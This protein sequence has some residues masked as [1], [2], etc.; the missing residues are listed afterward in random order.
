MTAMQVRLEKVGDAA[1][2]ATDGRGHTVVID[3]PAKLG[4]AD[5]G[6]RP[7]E[8]FLVSLAS[9][10]A[11]DVA[12]ILEQQRQD[13][14]GLT[15][16][17]DGTRADAVPAVYQTIDLSFVARGDVAP[18]K[19]ERAVRLSVDKYCSVRAMLRDDV[20]VTWQARVEAP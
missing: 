11:L 4:G 15:V 16:A 12:M 1:Y 9:C 5:R 13:L 7:M 3:G 17:V 20:E 19:L 14:Q 6:M 18:S 10:S 2:E 8:L